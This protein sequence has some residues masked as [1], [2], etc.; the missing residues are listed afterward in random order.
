MM[1]SRHILL[2]VLASVTV[3]M[4]VPTVMTQTSGKILIAHRGASAYAPEHTL[5]A[6]RLAI[7]QRADYV[8]QDLQISKDGVLVCMHDLTLERT[9]N[10][11]DVFPDRASVVNG[12]KTWRVSDFTLAELKRLDAG[13][14]FKPEFKG[15]RIPTFQEAV[16]LV[17]GKAGLYPE[18]KEPEVYGSRGFDMEKLLTA[19]LEKNRLLPADA[20]T[21]VIIQSFSPAS[22][23]KLRA[24]GLK[25]P[26]VFLVSDL[27]ATAGKWLSDAGLREASTF[28]AGIGPAKALVSADATL[29]TRAH[30]IGLTVTPYTFRAAGTREGKTVKEEMAEFLYRFGV[31]ALFTDNPDQFPRR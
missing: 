19:A 20:K 11:K 1:H 17:R 18:T 5:A 27:D 2:P 7:E 13:S 22:L 15:E 6:Y 26:L 21:P 3:A 29:V 4:N 31:D 8:E 9:T 24:A 16:D 30:A 28:A 10:V 25:V 14:W 12:V 23:K